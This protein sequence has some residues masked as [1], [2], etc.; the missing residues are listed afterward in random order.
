MLTVAG[1]INAIGVT[2]FLSPVNLYDSG[3][4][5]TS[6]LLDQLTP[7]GFTLSL[8]LILL[9]IPLFL[10]GLKKEGKMFTISSI[11]VVAIYS[12]VSYL[13]TYVLPVDVSFA[14]PLAEQD[15]FLCAI[16]GGMISGMGSG[17]AIRFGGAMDGIEVLAVIF[18]K[19]LGLSVGTFVMIYNV[20]LYVIIGCLKASWIL[21][22]YSIV[23]YAAALKTVDF[24]VEGLDKAKGA[25][26]ITS[27]AK[28]V[29]KALSDE[30]GS[31]IT[32]IDAK[33]Y[34]SND[35][36]TMIYFVVNRFQIGRMRNL[37][38][39]NDQQAFVSITEISDV[40]AS[41]LKGKN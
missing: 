35:E 3:I 4:S 29:C 16:F 28:E 1:I 8:F 10:F 13:I 17:M 37:V 22:L 11:Y 20:V 30:F 25:I 12:L 27:K 2:M 5:G 14:S 18:A 7:E 38:H 24:I 33:G 26:I 6:M 23:T 36:K 19:R 34:Y 40:F 15:L 39:A 41:N 9:N 32:M 21:P 31:G